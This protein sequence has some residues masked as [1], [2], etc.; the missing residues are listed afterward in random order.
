[1]NR[2]MLAVLAVLA[3]HQTLAA[4]QPPM[5]PGLPAGVPMGVAKP[6]GVWPRPHHPTGTDR[7]HRPGHGHPTGRPHHSGAPHD[8]GKPH[9]THTGSP[10]GAPTG[11]AEPSQPPS[12]A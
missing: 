11:A 9:H 10:V 1:M 8:T 5:D 2:F 4:P 12:V 3:A 6:T 7:P